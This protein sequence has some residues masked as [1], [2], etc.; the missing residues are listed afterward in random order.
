MYSLKLTD[1]L[2][3]VS[4]NVLQ[5]EE[6]VKESSFSVNEVRRSVSEL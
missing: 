3:V 6:F 1:N 2:A 5:W 4:G